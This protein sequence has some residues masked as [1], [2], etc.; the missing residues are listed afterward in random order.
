MINTTQAPPKES[1]LSFIVHVKVQ[2]L[3]AN[4]TMSMT[5]FILFERESRCGFLLKTKES[6]RVIL[7]YRE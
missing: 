5:R 6:M 7:I 2:K 4:S 1:T 3:A